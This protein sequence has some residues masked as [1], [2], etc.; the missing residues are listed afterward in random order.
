[1]SWACDG[2]SYNIISCTIVY[3]EHMISS[4]RSFVSISKLHIYLMR[5]CSTILVYAIVRTNHYMWC[6]SHGVIPNIV[7]N[8]TFPIPCITLLQLQLVITKMLPLRHLR[9]PRFRKLAHK[10]GN[11]VAIFILDTPS[12]ATLHFFQSEQ[13]LCDIWTN[14][15]NLQ[16]YIQIIFWKKS[17]VF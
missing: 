15:R 14:G 10:T 16:T 6:V 7:P 12:A 4:D 11:P 5:Q 9:H 8:S 3:T 1:M 13:C 2:L 17:I